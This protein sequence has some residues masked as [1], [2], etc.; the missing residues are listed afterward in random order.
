M[1]NPRSAVKLLHRYFDV[2][3]ELAG[4]LRS[5][6]LTEFRDV[7]ARREPDS[8][9][10]P[11]AL[12]DLLVAHNILELSPESDHEWSIALPIKQAL[13][14][15]TGRYEATL[16]G[17]LTG[18][19]RD[20]KD[21]SQRLQKH[22]E[23]SSLPDIELAKESLTREIN[24]ALY[25]S[26]EHSAGIQ[27]AVSDLKREGRERSL[28]ERCAEIIRLHDLHLEPIK[29]MVD[30]GGLMQQSIDGLLEIIRHATDVRGHQTLHFLGA[31]VLRFK[32]ESF[33]HFEAARRALEPLYTQ[34]RR[35]HAV[36]VAV[37][38]ALNRYAVQG[39]KAW[40]IGRRLGAVRIRTEGVT[41]D[42]AI[43]KYL[44]GIAAIHDTSSPT[45]TR[46][47]ATAATSKLPPLEPPLFV[48]DVVDALIGQP[49][50]L[51]FLFERFPRQSVDQLLS[52]Y[53]DL[54]LGRAAK[55]CVYSESVVV[56]E[57]RG[58]RYTYHAMEIGNDVP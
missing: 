11:A 43:T 53:A 5:V 19:L 45:R 15:L 56:R 12:I 1:R 27:A 51:E 18:I 23:A 25:A 7:V 37:A 44:A 17:A 39:G 22:L 50:A 9:R 4:R 54:A 3:E 2:I 41:T 48:E 46:K 47:L 28:A 35:D 24:K 26:R 52:V 38:R 6:S 29:G 58:Y 42:I 36:S 55:A 10:T 8:D 14:Y 16:P 13:T 49:D 31:S 21:E 34:V 32:R 40:D 57:F 20:I 30:S 33:E